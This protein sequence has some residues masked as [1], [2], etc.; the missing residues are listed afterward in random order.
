MTKSGLIAYHHLCAQAGL[1]CPALLEGLLLYSVCSNQDPNT[2][3]TWQVDIM[4]LKSLVFSARGRA[5]EAFL[6]NEKVA[7]KTERPGE[8]MKRKSVCMLRPDSEK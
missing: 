3:H 2:V 8:K 5:F 1:T 6:G 4:S 7:Q